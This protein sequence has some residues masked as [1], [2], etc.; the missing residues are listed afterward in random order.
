MPMPICLRLFWHLAR[1][2][3]SRTFWTAGSSRPMSTAM[4]AMTTSSSI[5]VKPRRR[6]ERTDTIGLPPERIRRNEFGTAT[7]RAPALLQLERFEAVDALLDLDLD[8]RRRTIGV[9]PAQSVLRLRRG[10]VEHRPVLRR[11]AFGTGHR[12][13]VLARR[14]SFCLTG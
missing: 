13:D 2:A 8:L 5:S 14:C 6:R 10:R 11:R 12:D 9:G 1:A 3:A 4:I 7:P